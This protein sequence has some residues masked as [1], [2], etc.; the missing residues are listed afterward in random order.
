[1][2]FTLHAVVAFLT[3]LTPWPAVQDPAKHSAPE[4]R[5]SVA[6]AAAE[7]T[8]LLIVFRGPGVDY[9]PLAAASAKGTT[10]ADLSRIEHDLGDRVRVDQRAFTDHLA[11]HGGRV[12]H[13]YWLVN[14]CA[15]AV[16]AD[17]VPVITAHPAVLRVYPD[18]LRSP[19]IMPIRT[20][21]DAAHHGSDLSQAAG[22]LGEG[23]GVAIVDAGFDTGS[24]PQGRPHLG[25]YPNGS[26]QL[27]TSYGVSG[28]RVAG[29][30]Q[31]GGLPSHQVD[32]HGTAVSGVIAGAKWSL[33]YQSDD[34]HAPRSTMTLLSV[35][36]FPNGNAWDSSLV[37]AWQQV[38]FQHY[39]K[40]L[41]A[42]NMSYSGSPDPI[43]PLT[44]AIDAAGKED[45]LVS[46]AAGNS[47]G[48]TQTSQMVNNGLSIGAVDAFKTVASF[49]CRGPLNGTSRPFPDLVAHGVSV[50]MP[51]A[52][53]ESTFYF[54]DGTSFAAPQVAGAA[55]LFRSLANEGALVTRASILATT[56][57]VA[58]QNPSL[59]RNDYGVGYLRADRLVDVARGNRWIRTARL[60]STGAYDYAMPVTAGTNYN[61]AVAWQRRLFNVAAWSNLR[62]DVYNNTQLLV[63]ADDPDGTFERTS[64]VSPIT[65]TVQV[66][67]TAMTIEDPSGGVPIAVVCP[68][69]REP[70]V[71]WQPSSHAVHPAGRRSHAMAFDVVSG[72]TVLFGGESPTGFF[73]DHWE[74]DGA[75]WQERLLPTPPARSGHAMAYDWNRG[76]L[77]LFGGNQASGDSA[78]TWE[79]DGSTW[80][81][82]SNSGPPARHFHAMAFDRAR[83]AVIL[84]GGRS[85]S[86]YFSDTWSWN[87][88]TWTLVPGFVA[89]S[90]RAGHVMAYDAARQDTVV[91]GGHDGSQFL[92]DTWVLTSAGW[93]HAIPTV[94]PP[95]VET[96]A[97]AY[98]ESRE[99]VVVHGGGTSSGERSDDTW[100]WNGTSWVNRTEYDRADHWRRSDHAMAYDTVR[101]RIVRFGGNINDAWTPVYGFMH[102]TWH[103]GSTAPA[104]ATAHGSGCAGNV[105]SATTLPWADNVFRATAT[106]LPGTA[107]VITVTSLTS[108]PQGVLPLASVFAQGQPGCDLLVVPDILGVLVTTTG[109][110]QSQMFLP[111]SPPL[112]GVTFFHQMI[113][114]EVDSLGN[115]TAITATNALRLTGGLL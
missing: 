90:A 14:G 19:A 21:T 115:W 49:S 58:G 59:G 7:P 102:D 32:A 39:Q 100:E 112:V 85:G 30:Y 34:G 65:G 87:G 92:N 11:A 48:N 72:K 105:L 108:I 80:T 70:A 89:P 28:S 53:D 103:Y 12:L 5:P 101:R 77:V 104:T 18:E 23:V 46:I 42:A 20:S 35:A 27:P 3:G 82:V 73:G 91:F 41:V 78:D 43:H 33:L 111:N 1:M 54:G 62:L 99:R 88:S 95:G 107:I 6:A 94:A 51:M 68:E 25:L 110:A 74:F 60:Y 79:F 61:L 114:I 44:M 26:T 109:T 93:L 4:A 40:R 31:A 97:A 24:N 16:P 98:D 10:A 36:D 96:P 8:R 75:Q 37:L 113:P 86:T 55:T 64:F 71:T 66:R 13:Q 81:N 38:V 2:S 47:A 9:S 56:E 69:A 76:R 57:S 106:G 22:V 84:F 15:I 83:N 50:Y 67:I 52:E 63:S 29:I 45:I 17:A